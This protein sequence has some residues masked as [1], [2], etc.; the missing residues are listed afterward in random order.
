MASCEATGPWAIVCDDP[1]IVVAV[2]YES[3]FC[4]TPCQ[5][6]SRASTNE[7]GS[8]T[9]S[10][11]RV[12]SAQKLPSELAECRAKPRISAMAN[13]IPVAADTKFCTVRPAIWTR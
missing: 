10:T 2:T 5:T 12:R 4:G 6:S 8:N 1:S 9:H 13:A 3:R 7:M 11:Q